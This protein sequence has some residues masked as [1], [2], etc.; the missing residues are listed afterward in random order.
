MAFEISRLTFSTARVTDF[1]RNRRGSVSRNSNAS[2]EPLD[3]PEGT[4][5]R[6]R[7]PFCKT[8]LASTVGLP[9]ESKIWNACTRAM[10]TVPSFSELAMQTREPFPHHLVQ[11]KLPSTQ[12]RIDEASDKIL[13]ALFGQILHGRLAVNTG[14][15]QHQQQVRDPGI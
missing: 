6:P 13:L 10:F 15:H 2:R 4:S 14:E 8:T 5:P 3:A 12:P 11:L 7:M 9:R 1:P